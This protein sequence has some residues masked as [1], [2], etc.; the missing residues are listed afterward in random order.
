M[1]ILSKDLAEDRIQ[2]RQIWPEAKWLPGDPCPIGMEVR[3]QNAQEYVITGEGLGENQIFKFW[4]R[5]VNT[6]RPG[7]PETMLWPP[8]LSEV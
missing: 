6:T 4:W 5:G 7:D 1:I 3:D 8:S 2:A